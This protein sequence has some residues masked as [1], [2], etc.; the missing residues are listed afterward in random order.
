MDKQF[1][2]SILLM[3]NQKDTFEMLQ[4][5]AD[6]R[7]EI[8]REQLEITKDIGAIR[9]IQGMIGELK[10]FKTLRDQVNKGAE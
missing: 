3:V 1:Y 7:V 2:R 4:N 6:A 9:E 8:L 10:R 5:Y